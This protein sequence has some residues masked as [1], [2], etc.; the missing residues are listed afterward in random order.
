MQSQAAPFCSAR[1]PEISPERDKLG[2]SETQVMVKM[3]SVS[4]AKEF[5]NSHIFTLSASSG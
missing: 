5:G 3:S 2:Y 1:L 4:C